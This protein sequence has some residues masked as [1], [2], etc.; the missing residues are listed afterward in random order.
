MRSYRQGLYAAV[1]ALVSLAAGSAV[2]A[3]AARVK[4]RFPTMVEDAGDALCMLA[5]ERGSK[6]LFDVIKT[7]NLCYFKNP[8]GTF[9]AGFS[10]GQGE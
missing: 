5:M 3:E 10:L 6:N 7:E 8:N 2:A 9:D 1:S 4:S